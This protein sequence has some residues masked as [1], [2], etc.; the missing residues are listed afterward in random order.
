[1]GATVLLVDNYDSFVY[2]L[3]QE[4]GELGADPVVRRNDAVDVD[5]IR[6]LGCN[7]VV[8]SPG[9]GRPEGA[10]ISLEAITELAGEVPILGVCLGHQ[11]IGQAFGASIVRAPV[12]MHGKTSE[13]HHDGRGVFAGLPQPLTATRYH[14]LVVDPTTVPDEL[15]V[16]ATTDDGVI[17]GLRHRDLP[18]EGV[19]FHPESVLTSSGPSLLA[20][21]LAQA[22]TA[23]SRQ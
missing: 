8:I 4:L 1:M 18:V 13:V 12:L 3:V 7:L 6:A 14:S 22:T 5:G 21:F 16:T 17:M 9:P 19:Q 10:G 11:A 23:R 15:E 2:N 20:N